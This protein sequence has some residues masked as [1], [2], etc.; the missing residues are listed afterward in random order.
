[1]KKI[2]SFFIFDLSGLV[3]P[4]RS[5]PKKPHGFYTSKQAKTGRFN[6]F[7]LSIVGPN[8]IQSNRKKNRFIYGRFW[9]F[10]PYTSFLTQLLL[11]STTK[12]KHSGDQESQE[13]PIT[14]QPYEIPDIP[15]AFGIPE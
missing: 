1:M 13:K 3:Q 11:R 12:E 5:D 4:D 2:R 9:I 10:L 14:S 8:F 6:P 15:K 7:L